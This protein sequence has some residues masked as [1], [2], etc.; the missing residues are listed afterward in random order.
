MSPLVVL[1]GCFGVLILVVLRAASALPAAQIVE[2]DEHILTTV[3]DG[4]YV[5]RHTGAGRRGASSGGTTVVVGNRDVLVVDS[6]SAPSVARADI[7][8]IRKWTDKPVRYL[9]NTHWHGDHTWGNKAY[10]DA[11]PGISI[12]AHSVTVQRMAGYLPGFLAGT[13][14]RPA[15]MKRALETGI[16]LD[17]ERLSEDRRKDIEGGLVAAQQRADE[18]KTVTM[19]LPTVSVEQELTVD[20]GNRVVELKYLGRGNTAGD[21]IVW[22]PE[23]KVVVTGDVLVAPNP[24]FFGGFPIEWSRTLDRI[25]SLNPDVVVPGH[26][27]VLNATEGRAFL[28][29]VRDWLAT[30]STEVRT[31]IYG[32]GNIPGD[33]DGA[34]RRHFE[35]V[36][37]AVLKSEAIA[38]LRQRVAGG[39]QARRQFFDR[40]LPHIIDAAYREAWGD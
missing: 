27:A 31:A 35:R 20:L 1:R 6:G 12:I 30:V 19:Q 37:E 2:T 4:I 16:D 23:K 39:D 24:F 38:T 15:D 9:V 17:G 33:N 40:T 3:T 21:L 25:L 22:L 7:A 26:G 18:F 34:K 5:I 13:V 10:V 28:A 14:N 8:V 29:L 32:L 11:F 36:R